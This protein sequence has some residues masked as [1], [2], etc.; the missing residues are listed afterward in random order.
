MKRTVGRVPLVLML[1]GAVLLSLN[2]FWLPFFSGHVITRSGPQDRQARLITEWPG[3]EAFAKHPRGVG[4]GEPR[5]LPLSVARS[6]LPLAINSSGWDHAID[7]RYSPGLL[8]LRPDGSFA[9]AGGM[10]EASGSTRNGAPWRPH[11]RW[12]GTQWEQHAIYDLP[13]DHRYF[14]LL[15]VDDN[16]SGDYYTVTVRGRAIGESR[17]LFFA[18]L[19]CLFGGAGWVA[20][21]HG[22]RNSGR[23]N[24]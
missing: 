12:F 4:A 6:D 16:R 2:V 14:L 17:L 20:I 9:Y 18:G 3:G 8:E 1:A 23:N 5:V 19:L 21:Q 15:P 10:R 11:L 7:P 13:L 24:R 22:Q